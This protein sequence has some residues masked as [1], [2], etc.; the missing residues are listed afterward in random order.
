MV[1]CGFL[2][3]DQFKTLSRFCLLLRLCKLSPKEVMGPCFLTGVRRLCGVYDCL[4]NPCDRGLRPK[5][6]LPGLPA[7]KPNFVL[8]TEDCGLGW[9]LF[10]Q[11]LDRLL[12]SYG[13]PD[14]YTFLVGPFFSGR[15]LYPLVDFFCSCFLRK[16]TFSLMWMFSS[17]ELVVTAISWWKGWEGKVRMSL[18][19]TSWVW[20][21]CFCSV[22][23]AS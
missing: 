13:V 2:K 18:G 15:I 10:W 20:S 21:D 3:M 14:L 5:S 23:T 11:D 4:S 16:V 7:C 1:S 8:S 19:K 12:C 9:F 17:S 6:L 22:I